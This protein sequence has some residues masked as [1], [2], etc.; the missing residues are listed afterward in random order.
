M[1]RIHPA[2]LVELVEHALDLY[3][4]SEI[5]I[6]QLATLVR[7]VS[8]YLGHN[9]IADD[10]VRYPRRAVRYALKLIDMYFR[11]SERS[12]VY[13]AI[14]TDELLKMLKKLVEE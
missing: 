12:P 2:T 3:E 9:D 11:G 4:R 13:V 1:E 7:Y 14:S 8:R 6:E 10:V 5:E